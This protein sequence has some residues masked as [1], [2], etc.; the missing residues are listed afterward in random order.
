MLPPLINLVE[1]GK[2]KL[3]LTEVHL[4]TSEDIRIVSAKAAILNFLNSNEIFEIH[5]NASDRQTGYGDI[6][7]WNDFH[8]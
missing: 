3:K 8:N 5:K 6:H 1:V 2:K 7:L 4:K